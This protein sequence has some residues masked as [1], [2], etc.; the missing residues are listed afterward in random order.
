MDVYSIVVSKKGN[1]MLKGW[2]TYIVVALAV[3]FN[4][5]VSLGYLDESLRPTV[6]A[7]LG[8]LGLGALRSGVANK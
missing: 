1:N 3:I 2:K 4:G 5:C 8:F 7:I 6:N